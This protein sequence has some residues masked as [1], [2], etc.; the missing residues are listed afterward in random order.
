MKV[1]LI[2]PPYQTLTSN[3]GV[4]HQVPLG[5]LMVGGAL[6]DA[7]HRVELLDAEAKRFSLPE[8]IAHVTR[9]NPDVV[10]TGHAGSTP[11][12]PVCARMLREIKAAHSCVTV[13]GGVYPTYHAEEILEQEVGID[14]IVRGEGEATVVDLLAVLQQRQPERALKDVPGIT[15][16]TEGS[17]TSTE[18]RP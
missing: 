5:L 15:F 14:I 6:L 8:I 17:I 4:G 13:Y 10:M 7:Q 18:N 9:L 16:S 1:L 3:L 11:A 12:H 2:N